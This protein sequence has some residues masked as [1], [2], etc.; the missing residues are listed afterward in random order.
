MPLQL[1]L[2]IV[3]R[4][5]LVDIYRALLAAVTVQIPLPIAIDV[6]P[7][8]HAAPFDRRFPHGSVNLA[9]P[10]VDVLWES[11]IY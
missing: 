1:T 11:D 6:E 2:P 3:V 7:P 10:P 5:D 9:P 4:I 8:D